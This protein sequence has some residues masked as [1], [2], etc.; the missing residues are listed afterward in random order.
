MDL[1]RR[2]HKSQQRIS[3]FAPSEVLKMIVSKKCRLNDKKVIIVKP[4]LHAVSSPY[5]F[6][7]STFDADG[8]LVSFCETI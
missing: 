6:D 1:F 3:S 7:K 2:L 8:V 5:L 4:A